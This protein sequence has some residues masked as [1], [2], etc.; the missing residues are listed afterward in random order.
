[1][2]RNI[3]AKLAVTNLKNNRKTYMP[4]ILTSMLMV[5]MFYM[6]DALTKSKD[7]KM[8]TLR[9][10]LQYASGVMVI[11]SV[12]FL[13][14]TNSF[15]MKQR[16]N[17][18]GVYNVLG[19]GK[20]HI[21]KM[22][23]VETGIIAGVSMI[24]G[25]ILGIIFG[26]MMYLIVLKILHSGVKM[27]FAVSVAAIKDSI[28]LFL[29]IFLLTFIYN[30]L[31]V[32]LANPMELLYGSSQGEKEPKTRWLLA[33]VGVLALGSGYFIALTTKE[34]LKALLTFFLAVVLVIIGTYALFTAGSIALLKILKKNKKYYYR[35]GHFTTISGMIYRMKQNAVGLANICILSTMV[36]VM[37]STTTSL[38][39]GMEDV[40]HTRFP[41]AVAVTN[42]Q[43][44]RESREQLQEV[45]Q[46]ETKRLDLQMK[47]QISYRCGQLMASQSGNQ[48]EINADAYNSSKICY[49]TLM[50]L[51]D[52]NRM[53]GKAETLNDNEVLLYC[54]DGKYAH[55]DL[56]IA[57][58]NFRVKRQIQKMKAELEKTQSV[59]G[60]YYIVFKNA[61][62][63]LNILQMQNYSGQKVPEAFKRN[64]EML[65]FCTS[66][67]LKGENAANAKRME[68]LRKSISSKV[69]NTEMESRETSRESFY[70]LYGGLFFIGIYL[71]IL[72]LIATVLIIYYKQISEGF[73]DRKRFQIMQNVG[74]SKREVRRSIKS[75][76]LSVFFLPLLMAILHVIVAFPIMVKLLRVLNLSNRSLFAG[77]SAVT[78][79]IFA[80]FYAIVYS[81]TAKEYYRIVN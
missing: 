78:I 34:P 23:A 62:E 37:I 65:R 2:A 60:N 24:G 56:K 45:L 18:I 43:T 48:F 72:F 35:Q 11:F 21:A 20:R 1:M 39:A 16:K 31:Q 70:G 58:E 12:I 44:S 15:L 28:A 69:S 63:I 41:K 7:L 75:Q 30:L 5:M 80:V 46:K 14:Y 26:K 17:E 68:E 13:F 81:L 33:L 73:E 53:E 22:M 27:K 54:P 66:F 10:C 36:L 52:Y 25:L 79:G 57:K 19:M 61:D 40:L 8:E 6:F 51:E 29:I 3:Y 38:Y 55:Y 64:Q 32:Q 49:L 71:G 50:P 76:I 77:C 4:Y 42:Y 9:L 59:Y 67:D 74:M 47:S